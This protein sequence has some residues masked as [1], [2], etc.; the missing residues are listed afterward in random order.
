MLP[1][2][3]AAVEDAKRSG[4]WWMLDDVEN[5]VVPDDLAAA[6]AG[7]PPARS[8]WDAFPP[9]ARR[10]MLGWLVQAVRPQTRA[11]R[12]SEIAD[13]AAR[14]ERAYPPGD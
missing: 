8:K 12:I 10:A 6:L 13:R 1:A 5:L 11:T 3:L 4:T 7:S 2:G 14:N 9:S